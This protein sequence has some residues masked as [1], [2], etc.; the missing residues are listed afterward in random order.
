[1]FGFLK[2]AI[3]KRIEKN[4]VKSELTYT[5]SR[6]T[7][8]ET[9]LLKR[10]RIP[11]IGDWGRIYPPINENGSINL[12]NLVFGG[13]KNFLRLLIIMGLL[14]IIYF[15]ATGIIGAGVEYLN[16]DKYVIIE[17]SAFNKFCSTNLINESQY[18]LIKEGNLSILRS[19]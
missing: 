17:R 8:T 18:Q 19:T 1:M 4:A 12:I 15:W 3:Q 7:H 16:G 6:G 5:D 13:K 9:V 2:K 10:S 14:A 11:L